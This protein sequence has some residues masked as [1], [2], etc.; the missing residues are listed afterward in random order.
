MGLL[1]YNSLIG[2]KDKKSICVVGSI[3]F[4]F[5]MT[6][7]RFPAVGETVLG[8]KFATFI[9]G[10]GLN[11][12]V[13]I[14]RLKAPLTFWG[15][16]GDDSFGREVINVLQMQGFDT[17]GIRVV[18]GDQTATGMIFV[19]PDGTNMIGG[20]PTANMNYSIDEIDESVQD[21][22]RNSS[23]VSL[24][25]EIPD[26]VNLFVLK[27]AREAG[28]KT[29]L[30]AAPYHFLPDS[31]HEYVDYWVVNEIEASQ[32][33]KCDIVSASS[34][35]AMLKYEPIRTGRESWVVTLG[36]GGAVLIESSGIYEI[37]GIEVNAVD[38]T[39]AG[40]SFTGAFVV[41]LSEGMSSFEAAV[42]ANKVAA[43]S[44][45]KLGGMTGLPTREEVERFFSVS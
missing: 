9:G 43:L 39:G 36:K 29:V 27:I 34:C 10:K 7:P 20:V 45:T 33:F 37:P 32:F 3:V 26:E 14:H 40:D 22:I 19:N 41:G 30:N 31:I 5:V 18:K 23:F 12:A 16:V 24:Q 1:A 25:L 15:R 2:M 4:D 6:L 28:A 42:F 8:S 11:Q 21:S 35:H 13:Q 38:S 17:S 44:V